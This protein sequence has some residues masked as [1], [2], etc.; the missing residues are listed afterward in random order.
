MVS[1]AWPLLCWMGARKARS[2]HP[3][4]LDRSEPTVP[5]V[6]HH[7][8]DIQLGAAVAHDPLVAG[9][10]VPARPTDL[11]EL[12]VALIVTVGVVREGDRQR[13]DSADPVAAEV[14]APEMVA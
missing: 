10:A 2:R 4:S 7:D 11:T 13:A 12:G 8:L 9:S 6:A 3:A 5:G 14:M 1:C